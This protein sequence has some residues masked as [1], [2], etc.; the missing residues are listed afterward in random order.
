[1]GLRIPARF[2]LESQSE[3][4]ND[5]L[6][7]L[8]KSPRLREEPQGFVITV[9]D[10]GREISVCLRT[11]L[12]AELSCSRVPIAVKA[13]EPPPAP[14]AAPS[15][16]ASK[17]GGSE[18]PPEPAE[19]AAEAFHKDAF[20]L[21]VNLSESDLRSLDGGTTATRDAA[22]EGMR[23]LLGDEPRAPEPPEPPAP[24]PK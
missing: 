2:R 19:R 3:R 4:A 1:M 22:R 12:D 24:N 16:S 18:P 6:S 10:D 23:Q 9:G 15:G 7:L 5:T 17:Q 14:S 11:P 20:A 13:P 8:R 21:K